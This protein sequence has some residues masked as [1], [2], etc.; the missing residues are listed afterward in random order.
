MML[1]RIHRLALTPAGLSMLLLIISCTPS[2]ARMDHGTFKKRPQPKIHIAGLEKRIHA[3]INNERRKQGLSTIE[4]DDALAGVARKHSL[5]MAKR[6]YF[7]H[8]SPEGQDFSFRYKQEGYS[9]AIRTGDTIYLGAENI[10]LNNL[11]DS[12]TTINGEAFFDWNSEEK[13]AETTVE[14]WMKS[15]GHRKNILTPHWKHEG[16]GVAVSPDDKVYITQNFC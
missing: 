6:K 4:W 12:V 14:G 7:A 3:L 16:L 11:Y 10:A 2:P 15:P 9:C 1:S 5:D 13:I 8:S